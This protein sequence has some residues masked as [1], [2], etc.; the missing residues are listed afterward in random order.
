VVRSC[1]SCTACSGLHSSQNRHPLHVAENSAT[2]ESKS[3]V[4]WVSVDIGQRRVKNAIFK[5]RTMKLTQVVTLLT[6]VQKVAISNP[7]QYSDIKT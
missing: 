2:A 7:G 6:S 1:A 5:L 3:V 4:N